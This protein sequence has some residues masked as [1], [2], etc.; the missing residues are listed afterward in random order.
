MTIWL[1]PHYG[2]RRGLVAHRH[3]LI[4]PS[5]RPVR[6]CSIYNFK[7]ALRAPGQGWPLFMRKRR[8]TAAL[9][10]WRRSIRP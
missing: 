6:T 4:L 8:A 10:V 3:S 7:G 1:N 2:G 5:I 9:T